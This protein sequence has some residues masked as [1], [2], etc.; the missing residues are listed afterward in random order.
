[1]FQSRESCEYQGSYDESH[2][3]RVSDKLFVNVL[4]RTVRTYFHS[5]GWFQLLGAVHHG[6][7]NAQ[8]LWLRGCVGLFS[9]FAPGPPS[10]KGFSQ[11]KGH[12]LVLR[13]IAA[14]SYPPSPLRFD[15]QLS[16]GSS[17][18]LDPQS[19]LTDELLPLLEYAA[20]FMLHDATD[21]E[22]GLDQALKDI[23]QP[24]MSN[25]FL[26]YHR[27]RWEFNT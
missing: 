14:A 2:K 25:S 9:P 7:S 4:H 3:S 12:E 5:N 16:S 20:M 17:L 8:V 24:G 18:G 10:S 21:V 1:M 26:C 27:F 22:Q 23:L 15:S 11:S 19:G 6:N 13:P